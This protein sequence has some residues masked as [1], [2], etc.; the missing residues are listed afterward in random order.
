LALERHGLITLGRGPCGRIEK[1]FTNLKFHPQLF[2]ATSEIYHP[3]DE[4]RLRLSAQQ[5]AAIFRTEKECRQFL[6]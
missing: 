4:G 2:L 6:L 1:I 3:D 5:A